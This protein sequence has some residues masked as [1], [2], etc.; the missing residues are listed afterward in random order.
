MARYET[1]RTYPADQGQEAARF[2]ADETRRTGVRH[3]ALI[4]YADS[5]TGEFL[6]SGRMLGFRVVRVMVGG[7]A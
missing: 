2:A 5:P 7:A 4:R 6:G 3:R 1:A